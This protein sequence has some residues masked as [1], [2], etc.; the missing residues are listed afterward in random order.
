MLGGVGWGE[1][2]WASVSIS[3]PCFGD[4]YKRERVISIIVPYVQGLDFETVS[5]LLL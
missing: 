2:T 3:A 5:F 4:V 1:H